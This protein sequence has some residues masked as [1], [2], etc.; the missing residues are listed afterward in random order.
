[1]YH[2]I[3]TISYVSL[4]ALIVLIVVFQ[5]WRDSVKAKFYAQPVGKKCRYK[6]KDRK[7]KG[8]VEWANGLHYYIKP[9]EKKAACDL[10]NRG[11]VKPQ[12]FHL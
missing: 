7:L 8:R 11:D 3:F 1:M 9:N 12:Y 5:I 10:V 2:V 4:V 6:F